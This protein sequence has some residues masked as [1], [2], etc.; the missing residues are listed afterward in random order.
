MRAIRIYLQRA[1]ST[2]L[3]ATALVASGCPGTG[4][5]GGY[6][7]PAKAVADWDADSQEID[8]LVE[9]VPESDRLSEA[10]VQADEIE[11]DE[12]LSA[13]SADDC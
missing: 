7:L 9:E 8:E 3:V 6:T 4:T 1:A 11:A 12:A 5:G 2:A 13:P 10:D